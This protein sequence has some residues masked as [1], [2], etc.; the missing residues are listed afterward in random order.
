M[1]NTFLLTSVL[2]TLLFSGCIDDDSQPDNTVPFNEQLAL[3]EQL[4]DNY[5]SDNNIDAEEHE[6]GIR[7]V[8]SNEGTG[9]NP[10]V[11]DRIVA[12]FTGS[13]LSGTVLLLDTL[14]LTVDLNEQIVWSWSLILPEIKEGGMIT[15]YS[16]SGYAYGTVGNGAVQPN[17]IVVFEIELL[18]IIDDADDQL[19]VEE[20][21]ID[22]FLT[23][24][25]IDFE[26]HSSGI[27]YTIIEE[28]AGESPAV[29]DIVS[30]IYEGSFLTG[31]VFDGNDIAGP[32]NLLTL[33]RSWQIMIP[34]MK[35]GGKIK[36]YSPSIYCYGTSGSGLIPPNTILAFE[37]DLQEIQ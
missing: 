16:P 26:V 25:Q 18:A 14:G 31:Q 22:E 27:R 37:I 4:I 20:T 17:E 3:D 11:G 9:E 36:F 28:G 29:T 15:V 30:I 8:I 1:K 23:E 24:K 12:K 33:I 13:N 6:S 2:F 5:L 35:E 19:A 32:F 34:E 7:Y 10:V 21:I